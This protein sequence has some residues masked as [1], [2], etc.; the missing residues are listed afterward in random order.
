M[1]LIVA[2]C[3]V[4][5][6]SECTEKKKGGLSIQDFSKMKKVLLGKWNWCFVNERVLGLVG[7]R[8]TYVALFLLCFCWLPIKRSGI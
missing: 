8:R 2:P 6:A 5:W 4:K 1:T 3:Q 7:V